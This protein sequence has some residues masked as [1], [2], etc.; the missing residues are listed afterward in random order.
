MAKTKQIISTPVN[1]VVPNTT[2]QKM[3]AILALSKSI[4]SL[5]EALASTNVL[6]TISHNHIEGADIGIN[7]RSL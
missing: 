6:V 3:E 1:L 5:S 2:E 4:Q 7:L